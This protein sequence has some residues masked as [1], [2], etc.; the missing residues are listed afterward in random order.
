MIALGEEEGEARKL[1]PDPE[2]AFTCGLMRTGC[3]EFSPTRMAGATAMPKS[4][5]TRED[6]QL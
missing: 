2:A 3:E 6:A 4:F 5:C 1:A